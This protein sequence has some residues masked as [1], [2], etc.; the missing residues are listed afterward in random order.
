WSYR[1]T[2][3]RGALDEEGELTLLF[4]STD[5]HVLDYPNTCCAS[6]GDGIVVVEDGDDR[7][8]FIRGLKPNG[9]M[10]TIAQN[11]VDVRRQLIYAAGKAD[12]TKGAASALVL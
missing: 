3:H 9:S 8:N 11:L 2:K 12:D 5:K 4:E 7:Q 1:P 6:P 10:I